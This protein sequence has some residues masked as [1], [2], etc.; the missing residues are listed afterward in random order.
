MQNTI[1]TIKLDITNQ[2]DIP[3]VE[4]VQGD[5]GCR[6][7][8]IELYDKG[9]PYQMEST[10]RIRLVGE[11]TDKKVIDE[12]AKQDGYK[13]INSNTIQ[14]ELTE[15]ILFCFGQSN[16]HIALYDSIEDKLLKSLPF[17]VLIHKNY[18]DENHITKSQEFSHLTKAMNDIYSLIGENITS[19]CKWEDGFS[20]QSGYIY[21]TKDVKGI[22]SNMLI[23]VTKVL[24]EGI[25]YKMLSLPNKSNLSPIMLETVIGD[26]NET[27]YTNDKRVKIICK[28]NQIFLVP[29]GASQINNYINLLI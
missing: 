23:K 18:Y 17:R 14:V 29:Y 6:F 13:L 28:E 9:Q 16:L 10:L 12:P 27:G 20:L 1:Q 4:A 2:Y 15:D 25:L 19:Y 5:K 26:L 3:V 7:V 8:N 24:Q 21:R 22:R 11:G